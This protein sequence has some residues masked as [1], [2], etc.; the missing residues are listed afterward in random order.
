MLDLEQMPVLMF[1]AYAPELEKIAKRREK[2]AR[3]AERESRGR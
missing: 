1:E 3:D 2:A